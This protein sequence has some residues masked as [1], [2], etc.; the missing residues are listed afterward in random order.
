M[1]PGTIVDAAYMK[2]ELGEWFFHL[3]IEIGILRPIVQG[4][5]EL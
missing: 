1:A 2:K 3:L 5:E 4:R